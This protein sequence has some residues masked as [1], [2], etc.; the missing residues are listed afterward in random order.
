VPS[1]PVGL[2]LAVGALDPFTDWL[3][4]PMVASI[5][6]SLSSMTVVGNA[7]RLRDARL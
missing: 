6:M 2:I 4:H 5:A 1:S 3:L 7:L